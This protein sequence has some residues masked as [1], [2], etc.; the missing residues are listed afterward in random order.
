MG[1]EVFAHAFCNEF[2]PSVPSVPEVR[3]RGQGACLN[4]GWGPKA[5]LR[6]GGAEASEGRWV[7]KKC[8]AQNAVTADEGSGSNAIIPPSYLTAQGQHF[9]AHSQ[10]TNAQG[11]QKAAQVQQKA[12]HSQHIAAQGHHIAAHSQHIAAQG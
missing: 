6:S 11:Q 8:S 2:L 4:S 1:T 12:A 10:H 9:A 5:V 3:K 7:Q